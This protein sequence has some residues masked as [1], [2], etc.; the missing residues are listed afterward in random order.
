MTLR[1]SVASRREEL[2]D[3]AASELALAWY[4]RELLGYLEELEAAEERARS[5]SGPSGRFG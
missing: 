1:E 4:A 5:G 3:L 2:E